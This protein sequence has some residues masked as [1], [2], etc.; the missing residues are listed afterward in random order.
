[1]KR[2]KPGKKLPLVLYIHGG[3]SA[4]SLQT[5]TAQSQFL[6]A[7]G[8]LIFEPNYRGSNN[9]GNAFHLG[10]LHDAGEGP[11]RDIM[12]GVKALE[13]RGIVD[14]KKIAVSG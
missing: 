4:A 13:A 7:E 2:L 10:V 3:P 8:W 14:E 1:M 11:G 9:E 6:A 5:F 12:A